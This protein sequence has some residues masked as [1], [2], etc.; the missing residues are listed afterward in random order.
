VD[1]MIHDCKHY[2]YGPPKR[3]P[4]SPS[5]KTTYDEKQYLVQAILDQ[6]ND[7]NK[8]FGVYSPPPS[9]SLSLSDAIF[10]NVI[11]VESCI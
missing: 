6:Y 2:L 7:D 10:G 11:V 1:R 5:S 3:D 4:S 8:L 9:L